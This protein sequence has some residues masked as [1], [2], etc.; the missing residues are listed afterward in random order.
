MQ[1]KTKRNNKCCLSA[2]LA[3]DDDDHYV[4]RY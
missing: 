3:Y 1:T 4:E 2:D